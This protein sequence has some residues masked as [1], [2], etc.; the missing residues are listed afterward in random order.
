MGP[1]A[2][3]KV[4]RKLVLVVEDEYIIAME[5]KHALLD[6]GFEVL[7]PAGSVDHALDLVS[8]RR[9]DVAVLDFTL[10]NE[11]VTPVA[12]RLKALEV[13][14]ILTSAFNPA[15]IGHHAVFAGAPSLGKP[16]DMDRLVHVVEGL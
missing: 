4:K 9:P 14:F 1:P 7:G 13:P 15:D 12:V 3:E 11:T 10:V 6:G 5:L 2:E 16:T 8:E